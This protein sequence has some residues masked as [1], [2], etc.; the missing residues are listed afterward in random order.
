MSVAGLLRSAV[1]LQP[2]T[3]PLLPRVTRRAA[4]IGAA[5][6]LIRAQAT[7]VEIQPPSPQPDRMKRPAKGDKLVF[8]AGPKAG[9]DISPSNLPEGGPQ[10]MAWAADPATGVVRDGSRL[11]QVLVVRLAEGSLDEVTRQ[12]SAGGVVAYSAICRHA[13]CP[14]TEWRQDH[15]VLHCPC[16]N[17]EYDPRQEAKVVHGPALRPLA[18]LP[19]SLEKGVLTVAAPFI[20]HVGAEQA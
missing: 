18:S 20:G 5:L 16:H 10:V 12:R 14:V 19:L 2:I 1:S 8:A 11:N 6:G 15:E 4:V 7:A 3:V 17:S 13:L 9:K